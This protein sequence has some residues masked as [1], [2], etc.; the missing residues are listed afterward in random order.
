MYH[1]ADPAA[2]TLLADIPKTRP[3]VLGEAGNRLVPNHPIYNIS[4]QKV[5]AALKYFGGRTQL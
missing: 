1:R 3:V 4:C 5:T 2:A